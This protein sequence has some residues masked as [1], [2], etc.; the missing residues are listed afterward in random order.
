MPL[1]AAH[2]KLLAM[3]LEL[4]RSADQT[5]PLELDA[6]CLLSNASQIEIRNSADT[7]DTSYFFGYCGQL[8]NDRARV[9]MKPYH[10]T[11]LE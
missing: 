6:H 8:S 3:H 5:R 1:V 11:P 9:L 4:G 10:W 2:G 7:S